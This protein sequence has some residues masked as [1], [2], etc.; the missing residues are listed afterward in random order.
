MSSSTKR[1]L[2]ENV[3]DSLEAS[4]IPHNDIPDDVF[5][6]LRNVGSRVRKSVTEG[7]N[8]HRYTGLGTP[9]IDA[10]PAG[11]TLMRETSGPIFTSSNAALHQVFGAAGHPPAPVPST[12]KR[13]RSFME[14]GRLAVETED[15]DGDVT[16]LSESQVADGGTSST[17]ERIIKPLRRNRGFKHAQSLPEGLLGL[18]SSR[19]IGGPT[20]SSVTTIEEDWSEEGFKAPAIMTMPA[21]PNQV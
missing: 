16:M 13:A 7:Y 10:S 17:N 6:R 5:A 1:P 8:T 12:L 15:R 2:T 18:G 9:P 3:R 4:N 19:Q 20:Q 21:M 11:S 14:D